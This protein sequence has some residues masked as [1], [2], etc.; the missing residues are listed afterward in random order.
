LCPEPYPESNLQFL[1]SNGIRLFQFGIEGNKEP[2]VNI[3]DHKIRMA[4]KVLLGNYESYRSA[5]IKEHM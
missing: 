2:F 4:L 5:E 1:K 3:P